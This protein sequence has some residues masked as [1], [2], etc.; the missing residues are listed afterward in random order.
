MSFTSE[1]NNTVKNLKRIRTAV[2]AR[3]G[4]I[5][6]TAG[7]DAVPDAVYNIPVDASLGFVTD[8]SI[9]Y[10]KE[11]PQ[12]AQPYAKLQRLG[13][14][15]Y[16][17]ENVIP[18]PYFNMEETTINGVTF[19][20]QPNGTVIVNGSNT[21]EFATSFRLI[22]TV[23]ADRPKIP[24]GTYTVTGC[25]KGGSS[26]T[27]WIQPAAPNGTES[28]RD[29]GDGKTF[30]T[31]S[32]G[33]TQRLGCNI[34]IAPGFTCKNL[35]FKPMIVPGDVI[36]NTFLPFGITNVKSTSV[37]SVG[38][39]KIVDL[40]YRL[41]DT[42]GGLTFNVSEDRTITVDGTSEY[43]QTWSV[44]ED[45]ITLT[46]GKTYTLSGCPS[47]GSDT[48]YRLR[49]LAAD[50]AINAVL[51]ATDYGNGV[52]FVAEGTR[53][54]VQMYFSDGA[55]CDNI[56]FK[57]MLN[58]GNSA[59]P[60]KKGFKSSINIPSSLLN[61]HGYGM[62]LSAEYNNH[63][64][65]G[66]NSAT[67]VEMIGEYAAT[68]TE[69]F[70]LRGANASGV[71]VFSVSGLFDYKHV[72]DSPSLSDKYTYGGT[73]GGIAAM[74]AREDA[75]GTY[76]LYFTDTVAPTLYVTSAATTVEEFQA[77]FAGTRILYALQESREEDIT[78]RVPSDTFIKVQAGGTVT[79]ENVNEAAVPWTIN[80]VT[81]VGN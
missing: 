5:S 62:G 63:I 75:A 15:S 80:F 60:Y 11:T 49:I 7:L 4:D 66:S 38:I 25:P 34:V 65:W 69:A 22:T 54:Y 8:S 13:G 73:I 12:N 9:A 67:F 17:S 6:V 72:S 27:Y 19:S 50:L 48:T 16:K 81:K 74:Q 78:G 70:E 76:C 61:R 37:E 33:S 44:N 45:Y 57:P 53:Y 32:F 23:S 51:V 79:A 26:N 30:T 71:N 3:G 40:S 10:Q 36:T 42:I 2:L 39:N 20:P 31:S 1:L 56:V 59:L 24:K 35:V 46:P 14:M 77:E 58:E 28:Y 55:V 43:T 41:P 47:G 29:Y 18:F 68:G 64:T 21:Y 52:T